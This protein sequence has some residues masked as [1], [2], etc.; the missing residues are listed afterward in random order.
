M[1]DRLLLIRVAHGISLHHCS[2]SLASTDVISAQTQ[3]LQSRSKVP[4]CR[5]QSSDL[6]STHK[7]TNFSTLVQKDRCMQCP[8]LFA[9]SRLSHPFLR[10][11]PALRLLRRQLAP[12]LERLPAKA[13]H[14]AGTC[15]RLRSYAQ[16]SP[17]ATPAPQCAACF[18]HLL[19][20]TACF[21]WSQ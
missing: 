17:A 18:W 19:E 15:R 7:F 13:D 5:L 12:S 16:L 10:R 14:T 3:C 1:T 8:H 21:A 11:V 20:P 4:S 9:L 2:L 6:Q